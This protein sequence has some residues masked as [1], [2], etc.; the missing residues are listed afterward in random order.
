MSQPKFVEAIAVT[1]RVLGG[2]FYY[3][4]QTENMRPLV[5]AF[6]DGSWAQEWPEAIPFNEALINAFQAESPEP[7]NDAFQRLFVGPYALPSPPWGSVWLDRENVLFGD[8]TLALR[9]WMRENG[10]AFEAQQNEPEDHFGTLLMLAAWLKENQ[11]EEEWQQLLS[12]HL[13]PW[14]GRFLEAFVAQAAHPFYE[15]LGKLAQQ[16]LAF[17]QTQLLMPVADKKLYR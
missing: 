3:N 2:L 1:G 4:P 10:I 14:S 9:Q 7:L 15:A 17:W 11:R 16:T 5:S 6:R 13:L 8:S 12:W